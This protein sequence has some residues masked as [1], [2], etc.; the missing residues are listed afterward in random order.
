MGAGKW[1][2]DLLPITAAP[3]AAHRVLS[4]RLEGVRDQL[5]LALHEAERDTEYVHQLR[6]GTRRARAALDIFSCCLDDKMHRKA[7]KFLRRLRQAAGDARDWDVF[8][9]DLSEQIPPKNRRHAAAFDFL[10]GHAFGQRQIAQIQLTT[11]MPDYPF[12]FD[13]FL[14]DLLHVIDQATPDAKTLMDLARPTLS[15]R[16]AA[17]DRA[18]AADL[19]DYENLHQVRI[20]GKRLRYAMEVFA[21]CFPSAFREQVYAKVE[22][23]QEFL[24]RA[25]DSHVAVKRLGELGDRIATTLPAQW[26]RYKPGFDCLLR[27]HEKRLPVERQKFLDWW[28]EWQTSGGES[29]LFRQIQG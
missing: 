8:I 23:M 17:L 25:N 3:A 13:R 14:A 4:V 26:K 15:E 1:I 6:V 7:R 12:T 21:D 28:Q 27:F 20:A 11:V 29:E 9:L 22:E 24:G 5:G 19:D 18:A 2:S 16:L 10:L